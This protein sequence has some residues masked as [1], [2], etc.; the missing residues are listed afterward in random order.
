MA[1]ITRTIQFKRNQTA[2]LNA[3]EAKQR[4]IAQESNL[5]NGE[6][7]INSYMDSNSPYGIANILGIKA[8]DKLF[9]I[10]NQMILIYWIF[11]ITKWTSS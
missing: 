2:S 1:N 9:F 4:I 11:H 8:Q 6:F 7:I 10:D 3:A 5:S